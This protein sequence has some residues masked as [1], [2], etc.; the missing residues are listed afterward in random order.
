M[1][2]KKPPS[3]ALDLKRS[4]LPTSV[5]VPTP[6][7]I[8]PSVPLVSPIVPEVIPPQFN[9]AKLSKEVPLK[10]LFDD[11]DGIPPLPSSL[12]PHSWRRIV[13][14]YPTTKDKSPKIITVQP[15][16]D[17]RQTSLCQNSQLPPYS[18]LLAACF[19]A[20]I[21]LRSYVPTG[22]FL[23]ENLQP[24][25]KDRIPRLHEK[26][27]YVLR[28]FILGDWRSITFDDRVPC[29]AA[30]NSLFPTTTQG[31]QEIWPLLLSKAIC[32]VMQG[33][34]LDSS[35]MPLLFSLLTGW[36]VHTLPAS[37]TN[38]P[39]KPRTRHH[40]LQLPS[41]MGNAMESLLSPTST[42]NV[43]ATAEVPASAD[44]DKCWD[45]LL[46]RWLLPA[47]VV[48]AQPLVESITFIIIF[49]VVIHS[50]NSASI[51]NTTLKMYLFLTLGSRKRAFASFASAHDAPN[52]T[53]I[54]QL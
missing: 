53:F 27:K 34:D 44:P 32:K 49:H 12:Q 19:N 45:T 16:G 11:P 6:L 52:S 48:D 51:V 36:T 39:P 3:K 30:G 22:C 23:W 33:R 8:S 47:D 42:S 2:D 54:W 24:Q 4:K 28:V 7:P 26:S 31:S 14:I 13:D 29:D 20:I 10:A 40:G 17:Q 50:T 35:S 9:L 38:F 1:A 25:G 15:K 5:I 46:S 43:T 37:M 21:A 41:P 18:A